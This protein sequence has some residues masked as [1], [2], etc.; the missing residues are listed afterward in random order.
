MPIFRCIAL[1]IQVYRVL[2]E[3]IG[4]LRKTNICIRNFNQRQ[5]LKVPNEWTGIWTYFPEIFCFVFTSPAFLT[6]MLMRLS[7]AVLFGKWRSSLTTD[8]FGV[9]TIVSENYHHELLRPFDITSAAAFDMT[10]H[11]LQWNRFRSLVQCLALFTC[12][13]QNIWV[14]V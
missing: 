7:L 9:R 5:N 12:L 14:I 8:F 1:H 4:R 2:V 10:W 6:T 11:L 3:I 13:T